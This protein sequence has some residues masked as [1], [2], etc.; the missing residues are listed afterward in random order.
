MLGS[1]PPVTL[2]IVVY[3]CSSMEL[4]SIVTYSNITSRKEEFHIAK[5]FIIIN[6]MT[7][8]RTTI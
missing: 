7:D 1:E 6:Y 3:Y 5:S 8:V 2:L 4:F